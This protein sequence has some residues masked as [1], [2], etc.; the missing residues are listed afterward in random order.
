MA[1]E[2]AAA[3]ASAQ[4]SQACLELDAAILPTL[5]P[6]SGEV[7]SVCFGL[8]SGQ[9]SAPSGPSQKNPTL[10]PSQPLDQTNQDRSEGGSAWPD[11]HVSDGGSSGKQRDMGRDVV[12]D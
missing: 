7:S 9:F 1:C 2:G 4:G 3:G 8:Q 5:Y 6:E 12:S 10:V 11:G